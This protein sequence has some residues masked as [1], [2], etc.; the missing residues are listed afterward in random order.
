M[1]WKAY[2]CNSEYFIKKRVFSNENTLFFCLI[3]PKKW[4]SKIT[5]SRSIIQ[6]SIDYFSIKI[7]Y[8]K[9]KY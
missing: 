9:K 7:P 8:F 3:A 4:T 1:P 6:Y 5:V 2:K